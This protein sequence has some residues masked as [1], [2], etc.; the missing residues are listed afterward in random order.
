MMYTVVMIKCFAPQDDA[1]SHALK[2]GPGRFHKSLA[3]QGKWIEE[4]A[5]F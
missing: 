5:G 4:T 3:L 2:N 1:H